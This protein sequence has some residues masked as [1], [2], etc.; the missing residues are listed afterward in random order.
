MM[1][2]SLVDSEAKRLARVII[3]SFKDAKAVEGWL[4]SNSSYNPKKDRVVSLALKIVRKTL[5]S[6]GFNLKAHSWRIKQRR[7]NKHLNTRELGKRTED[8]LKK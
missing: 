7:R 5:Q 6:E 3:L 4:K 8:L 2:E 1:A